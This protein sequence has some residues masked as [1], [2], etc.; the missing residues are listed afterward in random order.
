[1]E[2]IKGTRLNEAQ[3]RQVFAAFVYRYHA[4]GP[5]RAYRNERAWL[6]DHAFWFTKTG[7]LAANRRYCEP[8]WMA[9]PE[10]Q[11]SAS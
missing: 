4:I 2:L 10:H 1:M 3:Q 9:N 5:N 11:R 7:R 8:A 6:F